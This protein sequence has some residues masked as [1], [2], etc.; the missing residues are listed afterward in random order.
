LE[1]Q[2]KLTL[3]TTENGYILGR[4]K[5]RKLQNKGSLGAKCKI[6]IGCIIGAANSEC[7][8]TSYEREKCP[9]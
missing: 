4:P 9:R 2:R 1:L 5:R 8:L 6:D 7:Q 3:T